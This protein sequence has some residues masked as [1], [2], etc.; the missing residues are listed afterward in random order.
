MDER[1]YIRHQWNW[2]HSN[3]YNIYYY[4]T[5]R[6]CLQITRTDAF[7]RFH[8]YQVIFWWDLY[9]FFYVCKRKAIVW[10]LWNFRGRKHV[11]W[12]F[13]TYPPNN[14]DWNKLTIPDIWNSTINLQILWNEIAHDHYHC[15]LI[16]KDVAKKREKRRIISYSWLVTLS[17]SV[18]LIDLDAPCQ[19]C[20]LFASWK[21]IFCF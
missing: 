21:M 3:E 1:K 20:S 17:W 5:L 8:Y 9:F 4:Y 19:G 7:L 2:R 6:F 11:I 18:W 12:Q 15:I 14:Q 13:L 16:N 10:I